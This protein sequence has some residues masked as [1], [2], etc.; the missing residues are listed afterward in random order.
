NQVA[1]IPAAAK[2]EVDV[3]TYPLGAAAAHLIGYVGSVNAED[4]KKHEGYSEGDLIGKRGLEQLYEKELKGSPGI[5]ISVI[6][7]DNSEKSEEHTSE[8]QSRF[9]LVCRLLLE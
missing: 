3:R 9:D 2:K 4:I 7:E 5:K 6:Q 8:L 1:D